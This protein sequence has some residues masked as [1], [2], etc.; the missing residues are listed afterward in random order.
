MGFSVS[1]T[2]F[3]GFTVPQA[4]FMYYLIPSHIHPV[5]QIPFQS[6]LQKRKPA[7][8]DKWLCPG[9]FSWFILNS[10]SSVL[11][12][13]RQKAKPSDSNVIFVELPTALHC[14]G[15]L[16]GERE[17]RLYHQSYYFSSLLLQLDRI[18]NQ[19]RLILGLK[20][21]NTWDFSGGPV[22]K[23]LHSQCRRPGFKSWSRNSIPHCNSTR[24][25]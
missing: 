22:A 21:Q 13:T 1:Y 23:T 11:A 24:C 25:K 18:P 4:L 9:T 10:S 15:F 12:T 8:K 2:T 16:S 7:Q 19:D 5:R 17:P 3:T 14:P 6:I 20:I